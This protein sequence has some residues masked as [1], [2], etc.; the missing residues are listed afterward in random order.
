VRIARD[1]V[2]KV[3]PDKPLERAKLLYRWVLNNVEDGEETDGARVVIGKHGNRWRGF[4]ML[5][6]ALGIRT[7]FA[8]ARN[9]L[10]A[11]PRGAIERA[12]L[13]DEPLMLVSVNKMKTWVVLENRYA[14]FGYIPASVRGMPAYLLEPG[15]PKSIK[16]PDGGS[17][18]AVHYE[19]TLKLALD[20]SAKAELSQIFHGMHAMQLRQAL[21]EMPES[22]VRDAIESR[23]LAP[24][25]R[26]AQLKRHRF[27]KVDD[28][29]SPLVLYTS[30]DVASFAQPSGNSLV[31]SPPFVPALF[32]PSVSQATALPSRQTPLLIGQATDERVRL[33]IAL[34]KGAQ[35]KT[36]LKQRRIADGDRTVQIEDR[37]Q[38]PKLV[39]E[40]NVKLPAGRVQPEEY[41]RFL[42][43]TRGASDAL[44][45]S[46]RFDVK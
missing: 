12:S 1:I 37:L 29:D 10:A 45:G 36:G 19:G 17:P 18:D 16:T 31:I 30:V 14:P 4:G 9:R 24:E 40:R 23:L 6:R 27:E 38:G 20:G 33:E 5:C 26:G 35:L 32:V 41:Q 11:E 43:F 42:L 13:Y 39:L 28:L 34:P 22:Q 2:G 25:L 3:G 44:S 46:I 15:K 8:L 21:S 7:T